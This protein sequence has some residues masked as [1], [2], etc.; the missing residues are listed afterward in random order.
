M[1]RATSPELRIQWTSGQVSS[2]M[3]PQFLPLAYEAVSQ[4]CYSDHQ[5]QHRLGSGIQ[6]AEPQILDRITKSALL[7]VSSV[8][9]SMSTKNTKNR[10]KF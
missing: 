10:V 8:E 4:I 6:I 2:L 5:R 7:D 3:R 1:I 9:N